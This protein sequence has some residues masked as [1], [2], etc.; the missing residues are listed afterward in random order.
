MGKWNPSNDLYNTRVRA[1]DPLANELA[2][3][4]RHIVDGYSEEREGGADAFLFYA[5]ATNGYVQAS[6]F[7]AADQE[8]VACV[9]TVALPGLWNYAN[10][11]PQGAF[12]FDSQVEGALSLMLEEGD[13]P[14]DLRWLFLTELGDTTPLP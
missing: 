1:L 13:W 7:N 3:F 8:P 10:K 9:Y 2:I 4:L 5:N 14:V 6:L 11:H 12:H